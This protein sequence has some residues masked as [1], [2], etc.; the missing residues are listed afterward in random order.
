MTA[1]VITVQALVNTPVEKVWELWTNTDH[2][3]KWNSASPEWHLPEATHNLEAGGK[4][5]YRMEAKDKSMGFDFTGTFT[6][7]IKNEVI[8]YTIDDN[9]KVTV[10]F[11][12]EGNATRIVESFEDESENPLDMQRTGWQA[13]MDNFKKYAEAQI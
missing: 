3:T 11:S 2:I 7:V 6:E 8:K 12:R 9:R 5:L 13:I 4:F 10:N 1:S